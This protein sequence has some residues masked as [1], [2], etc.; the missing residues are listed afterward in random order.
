MVP[1]EESWSSGAWQWTADQREAYANDLAAERSL[2]AVT[3][4]TNRS[5]GAKDPAN[6]LPPA[7]SAHC[8]Y[9]ADWTVTKLRWGLTADK[10]EVA[11]LTEVAAQ[12][13]DTT[14]S[15]QPAG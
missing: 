9:V 7:E 11:A 15:Y 10:A 5:K 3:A 14:V 1:L 2:V 4:K 13:P 8:T 6:W 12:C